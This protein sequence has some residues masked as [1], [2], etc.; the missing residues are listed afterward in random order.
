MKFKKEELVEREKE[1]GSYLLQ[2]FHTTHISERTGLS[3]KTI[4]AHI[5]NMMKK[6]CATD[7]SELTRILKNLNP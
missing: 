6:L 3:K 5:R 4:Y 2:G 1:I 7:T